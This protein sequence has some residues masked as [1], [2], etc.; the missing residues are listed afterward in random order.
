MTNFDYQRHFASRYA[1][2]LLL[3]AALPAALLPVKALRKRTPAVD[4][5]TDAFSPR[6]ASDRRSR[7]D[8]LAFSVSVP[9]GGAEESA[10]SIISIQDHKDL[11]DDKNPEATADGTD[12][13]DDEMEEEV[14]EETVE[15]SEDEDESLADEEDEEEEVVFP[16]EEIPS[17][18]VRSFHTT[19]GELADDEGVYTDGQNESPI[20]DNE[21]AADTIGETEEPAD[22]GSDDDDVNVP[23]ENGTP[24][25]ATA[26]QSAASVAVIDDALKNV[27]M[28][29]LRYKQD[30]VSQMRPDIAEEVVRNQLMRPTEG[31]PKNWYINPIDSNKKQSFLAKKKRLIVS[32]AV[33]GAAAL[34]IGVLKENDTVGD[35]VEEIVDAL[36]AIPKSLVAAVFAAK[37]KIAPKSKP[38][39]AAVAPVVAPETGTKDEST[40]EQETDDAAESTDSSIHSIKP[41]TTPEEVPDPEVDYTWLDKMLTRIGGLVKSFFNMK[42]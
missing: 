39:A 21:A 23:E 17:D 26:L 25:V 9:R 30:D 37:T 11:V 33:V 8:L 27:L 35:T 15:E 31:M 40:E 2:M 1:W 20:A 3:L 12:A 24:E 19:D 36:Q 14:A 29:E 6:T 16:T 38:A 34:S 5:S 10:K 4:L 18:D 22:C 28:T 13:E 7:K 41:G 32:I 42:I